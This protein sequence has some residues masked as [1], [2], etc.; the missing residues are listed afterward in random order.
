VEEEIGAALGHRTHHL[1]ILAEGYRTVT[2]PSRSEMV[3]YPH[4]W[5]GKVKEAGSGALLEWSH[6]LTERFASVFQNSICA[7][8]LACGKKAF[9]CCVQAS[10]GAA[11][12]PLS[13]WEAGWAIMEMIL[14]I[15]VLAVGG[16]AAHA[17]HSVQCEAMWTKK[18]LEWPALPALERQG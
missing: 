15:C 7:T 2:S 11:E 5:V 17:N 9:S 12:M 4:V 13:L 1:F 3:W 18:V 6:L 10:A 14:G 8:Q 16:Q